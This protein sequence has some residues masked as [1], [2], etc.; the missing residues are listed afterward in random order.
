MAMLYSSMELCV[1]VFCPPAP[2]TEI[3]HPKVISIPGKDKVGGAKYYVIW[4]TE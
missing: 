2:P 1:L 4:E 3:L